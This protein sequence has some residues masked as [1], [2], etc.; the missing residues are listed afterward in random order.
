MSYRF[1][2]KLFLSLA[3]KLTTINNYRGV[4]VMDDLVHKE[5]LQDPQK[6]LEGIIDDIVVTMDFLGRS[7][8]ALLQS[9][10]SDTKG[11]RAPTISPPCDK[12]SDFLNRLTSIR[13]AYE[14][15]GEVDGGTA[16]GDPALSNRA[17]R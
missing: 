5:G 14:K 4:F 15:A 2:Q 16:A 17:I 9:Q 10:F 8:N 6:E 11:D 12:Y 7:N 1:T 3:Y 13:A